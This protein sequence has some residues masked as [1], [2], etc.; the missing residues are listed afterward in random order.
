MTLQEEF[1]DKYIAALK[2][3]GERN[4]GGKIEIP[5][6]AF[7][8]K[9][10]MEGWSAELTKKCAE[11]ER[12]DITINVVNKI[13]GSILSEFRAIIG[14]E[15][16]YERIEANPDISEIKKEFCI[17]CTVD[18]ENHAV[19]INN[20]RNA[21]VIKGEDFEKVFVNENIFSNS[22]LHVELFRYG[23]QISQVSIEN[24]TA[25]YALCVEFF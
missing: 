24:A 15:F 23:I 22:L 17:G 13:C 8:D 6:F 3:I 1:R 21:I 16:S 12:G 2:L 14:D 25:K 11:Q 9:N 10:F 7:P 18:N 20:D 5:N 19:Q 4:T